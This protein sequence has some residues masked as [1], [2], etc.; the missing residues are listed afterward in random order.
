MQNGV[1]HVARCQRLAKFGPLASSGFKGFNV[2]ILKLKSRWRVAGEAKDEQRRRKPLERI[3]R[4]RSID[5]ACFWL[6]S[7]VFFLTSLGSLHMLEG[8]KEAFKRR[9]KEAWKIYFF[10]LKSKWFA[11]IGTIYRVY[12]GLEGLVKVFGQVLEGFLVENGWFEIYRRKIHKG[13]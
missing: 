2:G 6:F 3:F 4:W 13:A 5:S 7:D 1:F 10:G 8:Q 12:D 9:S 11:W